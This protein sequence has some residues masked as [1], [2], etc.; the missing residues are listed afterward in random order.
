MSHKDAILAIREAMLRR[1]EALRKALT[2]DL[3][4]L[5]EFRSKPSGDEVDMAF[6]PVQDEIASQLAETESRELRNIS[7]ALERMKEGKYGICEECGDRIP[8]VRLNAL[9][10][11]T[12]C[13]EC[14]RELERR[15]AEP[16]LKE[17]ESLL[18][19]DE[20]QLP[21]LLDDIY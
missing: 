19:E 18:D 17:D 3:S 1:R 6:R 15:E 2:G 10:W 14:Q 13:I 9:P 5:E 11:A 12:H 7:S 4:L 16:Y 8:L 20:V 21:L